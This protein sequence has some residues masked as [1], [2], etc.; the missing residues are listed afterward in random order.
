MEAQSVP[1]PN[2]EESF[3]ALFQRGIEQERTLS[4]ILEIFEKVRDEYEDA[5]AETVMKHCFLVLRGENGDVEMSFSAALK[6]AELEYE[7]FVEDWYKDAI[8]F[9]EQWTYEEI[10]YLEE[11]KAHFALRLR[12]IKNKVD[13]WYEYSSIAMMGKLLGF[14]E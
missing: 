11:S 6:K 8:R 10:A 12:A 4:V 13:Y 9:K 1:F 3:R 7:R 14:R 2:K 5:D